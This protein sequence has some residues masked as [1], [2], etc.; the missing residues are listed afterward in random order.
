LSNG[1]KSN[2]E[3]ESDVPAFLAAGIYRP[4]LPWYVP[5]KYFD[6]Y[7]LESL[8][9][10]TVDVDDLDDV[11]DSAPFQGSPGIE[12]G[13]TDQHEWV[14]QN[15]LWRE[16]VQG[17]LASITFADAMVGRI[18]SALKSSGKAENTIVVLLIRSRLSPG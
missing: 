3:S 8:Q 14:L 4:H 6:L 18:V 16:A 10:P 15:D 17:Y 11:P 1:W 12:M 9:L 7:P 5:G 2:F 13:P